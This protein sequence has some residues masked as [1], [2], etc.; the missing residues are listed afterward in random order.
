MLRRLVESFRDVRRS[1]P[2]SS[3]RS[4]GTTQEAYRPLTPLER[5]IVESSYW[6]GKRRAELRTLLAPLNTLGKEI[7]N[8]GAGRSPIRKE[9]ISLSAKTVINL[10]IEQ[11]EG[12][13]AV[14]DAMS[15]PFRDEQFDIVLAMRVLHHIDL[16]PVALSEIGRCTKSNGH[17]LICEPFKKVVDL[18]KMSGM[19]SHPTNV[20]TK[21]YLEG[22][23]HRNGL[24]IIR[25]WDRLYWFY[26]AFHVQKP[27]NA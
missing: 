14:A 21:D 13:T 4:K 7:L 6:D 23:F 22:Y 20:I 24:S 12:L 3:K 25:K 1:L 15:L 17:I 19:D 27:P 2:S 5:R 18:I 11:F 16:Y 9:K 26:Y 10:D 8:I